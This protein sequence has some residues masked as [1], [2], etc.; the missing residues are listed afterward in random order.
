MDTV[1][2]HKFRDTFRYCDLRLVCVTADGGQFFVTA[3]LRNGDRVVLA[4]TR[5]K[6]A[7]STRDVVEAI[8]LS[9]NLGGRSFEFDMITCASE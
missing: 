6:P 5:G 2:L 7:R 1:T 3:E 9:H 4:T 8:T